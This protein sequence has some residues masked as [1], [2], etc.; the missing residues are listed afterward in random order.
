MHPTMEPV[1]GYVCESVGPAPADSPT[2][3]LSKYFGKSV[4]LMYKGP[5]PRA[6][7]PPVTFPDL[8]A[9]TI[10]Q[11]LYALLLLSEE[12]LDQIH[13]KTREYVGVLGVAENW[14]TDK[15]KIEQ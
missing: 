1:D 4:R 7:L 2:T 14:D 12:S 5:R 6:V 8:K 10:Y 9:N 13:D 15:I 3:T 11:D